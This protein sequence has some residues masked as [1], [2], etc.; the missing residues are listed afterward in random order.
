MLIK[1]TTFGLLA[2]FSLG[3]S[4]C[5]GRD[6]AASRDV[7]A[8]TEVAPAPSA[9]VTADVAPPASDTAKSQPAPA[10]EGMDHSKMEGMDHSK[11]DDPAKK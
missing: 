10:M 4:A 9:P 1:M 11:M 7:S 6:D 2:A 3:L 5:G 8:A